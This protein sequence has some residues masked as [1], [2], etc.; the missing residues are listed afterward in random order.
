MKLRENL[1]KIHFLLSNR[2]D[3][4]LNEKSNLQSGNYIELLIKEDNKEIR[5]SIK[6]VDL[7]N[8]TF[9]WTYLS[10]PL[11]T[12]STIVERLSNVD[13]FINDVTDIFE[14]N[15]FDSDYLEKIK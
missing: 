6:K 10:N 4:A 7:E 9:N 2:F 15:R 11:D 13:G 8:N 12:N 14:K 3:V 5:A 1:N